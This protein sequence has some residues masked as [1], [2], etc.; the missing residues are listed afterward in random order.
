MYTTEDNE[1]GFELSMWTFPMETHLA[2]HEHTAL[3]SEVACMIRSSQ[4]ATREH[5]QL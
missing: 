2:F 1:K 3:L 5:P 4:A